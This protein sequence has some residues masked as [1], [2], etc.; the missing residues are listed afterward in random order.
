MDDENFINNSGQ[1][2]SCVIPEEVKRFNW[3]AFFWGWIWGLFN[4][5]YLTLIGLAVGLLSYI[6]AFVLG[7]IAGAFG[8]S[9]IAGLML[10]LIALTNIISAIV[11]LALS[12]WFGVKGN[13][14]AWQNK[15]W[16]SLKHFHDVQR[17]WAIAGFVLIGFGVV[18]I[19]A[20][21]VLP[22]LLM[23]TDQLKDRSALL[24]SV[25]MVQQA[26]LMAEAMDVKCELSSEGLTK[27]FGDQL[28]GKAD[29]SRF[30][31]ADGNILEFNGDGA[32]YDK[33]NCYVKVI[34]GKLN[35]KIGLYVEKGV[36]KVDYNDINNITE[37]Y[38]RK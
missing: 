37:K 32:C 3:G 26:S 5:S 12:I 2:A 23:N 18:G 4:K 36:V 28:I 1:G 25:S 22:S 6:I 38:R 17:I 11:G 19:V 9:A 16:K 33:D 31:L 27:C 20:A 21:M 7:I 14:W 29:G 24:K 8:Q 35:E 34:A 30:V 15:T 13:D 10:L